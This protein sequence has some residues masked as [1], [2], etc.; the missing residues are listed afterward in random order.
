MKG[1]VLA[2]LG[3]RTPW[4]QPRGHPH[5]QPVFGEP[6]PRQ[7]QGGG[8]ARPGGEAVWE[9]RGA[10]VCGEEVGTVGCRGQDNGKLCRDAD[11]SSGVEGVMRWL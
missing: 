5:V 6:P 7:G 1:W 9:R 10:F 8:D 2:S 4:P 11:S 3:P